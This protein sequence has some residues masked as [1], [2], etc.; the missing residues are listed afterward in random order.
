MGIIAVMLVP[1]ALKVVVITDPDE[2][3][4]GTIAEGARLLDATERTLETTEAG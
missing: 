2:A 3:V 1:L 4:A